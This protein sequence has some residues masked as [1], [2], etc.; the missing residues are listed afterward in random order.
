[1][2]EVSITRKERR[3]I[4]KKR[5]LGNMF[6]LLCI[7]F[8]NSCKFNL[9][10]DSITYT[11]VD[12]RSVEGYVFDSLDDLK[13]SLGYLEDAFYGQITLGGH[14]SKFQAFI[15]EGFTWESDYLLSLPD[16]KSTQKN[17]VVTKSSKW[18]KKGDN[19]MYET[20][21]E[22]GGMAVYLWNSSYGRYSDGRIFDFGCEYRE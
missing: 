13:E 7:L 17:V 8:L 18:H 5:V 11:T 21:Y 22:T 9:S 19:G 4:M 16:Y 20:G 10:G 2:I 14:K 15:D 12:G 6:A 3:K 1:M